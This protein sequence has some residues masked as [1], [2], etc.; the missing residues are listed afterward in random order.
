MFVLTVNYYFSSRWHTHIPIHN[1]ASDFVT[2]LAHEFCTFFK[3]T[4]HMSFLKRKKNT[5]LIFN[6]FALSSNNYHK[7]IYVNYLL[8]FSNSSWVW[9]RLTSLVLVG[10]DFSSNFWHKYIKLAQCIEHI[11]SRWLKCGTNKVAPTPFVLKYKWFWFDET[12][13]LDS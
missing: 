11:L 5:L 12:C 8:A 7:S 13:I 3:K 1:E 4:E 10:N 2:L 6:L 9:L